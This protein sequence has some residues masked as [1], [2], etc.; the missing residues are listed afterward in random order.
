MRIALEWLREFVDV[1]VPIEALVEH[2]HGLGLP[3]EQ[4]E[5]HGHD[6]VLDIE[7]TA[8]RPDCMSVL[9]VAREVA[10]ALGRPLR[11]PRPKPFEHPPAAAGRAAVEIEDP[12]GC[13]RFTAR[14]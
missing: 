2:L 13:P 6:T 11:I 7:L 4:V 5:S 8:N 3:V 9:G 1:D 10:L 14:V 12:E